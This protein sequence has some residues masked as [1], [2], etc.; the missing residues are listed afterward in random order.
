[1]AS[2]Q[3]CDIMLQRTHLLGESLR[4]RDSVPSPHDMGPC[5]RTSIFLCRLIL[6]PSISDHRGNGCYD[7]SSVLR[8]SF[9][10]PSIGLTL[11]HVLIEQ[12][13]ANCLRHIAT[14]TVTKAR[15]SDHYESIATSS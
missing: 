12:R 8:H 9:K 4:R 10:G 3:Q 7:A 6:A 15:I 5:H 1:M 2:V 14:E 13:L 11:P